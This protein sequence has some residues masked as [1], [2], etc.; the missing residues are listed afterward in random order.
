MFRKFC[1]LA[2]YLA[3]AGIPHFLS[4]QI[5]VPTFSVL[6]RKDFI[7][8]NL[9]YSVNYKSEYS[10]LILD[11]RGLDHATMKMPHDKLNQ[12]QNFEATIKNPITGKVIKKYRLKD[13]K[14][15]SYINNIS[16]FD[17]TKLKIFELEGYQTPIMIDIQVERKTNHNFLIQS[18]IPVKNYNQKLKSAS[19]DVQYPSSLGIRYKEENIDFEPEE[20]KVGELVIKK[21]LLENIEPVGQ[22]S[23]EENPYISIAPKKFALEGYYSNMESWDG[24]GKFIGQL[25]KDKDKLP[26][27]F[28]IKVQEMISGKD[29]PY[30]KISTLY[31][32]LQQNYRYISISLGIGG[33]MP[34]A[35][36]DVIATK[37]GECKALT[38]LMKGMLN[39]AG[40]SSQYTLVFGG[41]N[42]PLIDPEFPS[43]RFNHAFLRVPL[44]K[45]TLW[46]ECTNTYLPAGFAGSFTMDRD[47]LV[48][49]ENGGF[50]DRTPN[51]RT[52]KLHHYKNRYEI[53][54]LESGDAKLRGQNIY[55]GF[56]SEDLISLKKYRSGSDI[57]NY[58]NK[59]IGGTGVIIIDYELETS[60]IREVP[61][62]KV[63]YEG[64]VQRYGQQTTK[65]I[66]LPSHWK[67]LKEEMVK[68]GI[69]LWEEEI[70]I[71]IP[72][73]TEIESAP[74]SMQIKNEFFSFQV[75]VQSSDKGITIQNKLEV[76]FP[77]DITY[78]EKERLISEI[79]EHFLKN[80][81]LKKI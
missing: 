26:Q 54:M 81:I 5:E 78:E 67:K 68:S 10:L 14:E 1:L 35:S 45:D 42:P 46:L 30:E 73:E 52:Q 21:W 61:I 22:K 23:E 70:L 32:Y 33:W 55:Q 31:T 11:K 18:W 43:N 74:D 62:A 66:I 59:N 57:K 37:Y 34:M 9:D 77:I 64:I 13:L 63:S 69:L 44:E 8:L 19:L 4:A 72:T 12:I 29:E 39:E 79:N 15:I 27:D 7:V 6:E 56:P 28:K 36:E 76:N 49:T 71:T 24:F 48:I 41:D 60:Q 65:R 16:L 47:V 80:I 3:I 20:V 53:E 40:I 17:D 38:T 75:D 2:S 58:L 50:L 25:N 51:Y